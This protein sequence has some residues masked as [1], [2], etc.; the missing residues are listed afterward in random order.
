MAQE[1]RMLAALPE[2]L[3]LISSIHTVVHNCHNSSYDSLFCPPLALHAHGAQARMHTYLCK[4]KIRLQ[5]N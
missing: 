5:K 3:G 4:I 2:D 1:L